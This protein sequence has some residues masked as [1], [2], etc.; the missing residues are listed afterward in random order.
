MANKLVKKE[1]VFDLPRSYF[2]NTVKR[3]L[4]LLFLIKYLRAL[5]QK[6]IAPSNNDLIFC[7]SDINQ[8]RIS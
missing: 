3:N 2:I 1:L 6:L 5:Q 8:Y 7:K 4:F